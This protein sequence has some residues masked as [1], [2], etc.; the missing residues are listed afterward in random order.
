M[1]VPGT[2]QSKS[3]SLGH[4]LKVANFGPMFPPQ[5][6]KPILCRTHPDNAGKTMPS[7]IPKVSV[8]TNV[9]ALACAQYSCSKGHLISTVPA[10]I[11]IGS[12]Y[13]TKLAER[14]L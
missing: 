8:L 14:S 9:Q 11:G 7:T 2:S 1:M 4:R 5:N 10:L 13:E 6:P 12:R 3:V